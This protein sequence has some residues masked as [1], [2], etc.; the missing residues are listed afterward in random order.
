M[1]KIVNH[2]GRHIGHVTVVDEVDERWNNYR[3]WLCRC[4]CGNMVKFSSRDLSYRND[5]NCGCI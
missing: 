4:D 2:I 5:L 3:V 1:P